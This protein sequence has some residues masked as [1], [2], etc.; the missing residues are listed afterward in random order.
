MRLSFLLLTILAT[1][2]PSCSD[3]SG[4]VAETTDTASNPLPPTN[5]SDGNVFTPLAPKPDFISRE[6][7][8]PPLPEHTVNPSADGDAPPP[9][10]PE[11]ST[12]LLVGSGLAGIAIYRRR[13]RRQELEAAA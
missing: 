2:L 3:G 11:P 10:V 4:S 9:P 1:G 13:R 7:T 12:F 6:D 5:G 8:S